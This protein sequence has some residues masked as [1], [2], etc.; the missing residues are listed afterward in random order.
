MLVTPTETLARDRTV[1]GRYRLVELLGEGGYGSVWLATD[2]ILRRPV[3]IKI[4]RQEMR[5][6][7]HADWV[8]RFAR[9]ARLIAAARHRAVV[10]V[11]DFG[12]DEGDP[13]LVMQVVDGVSMF[14]RFPTGAAPPAAAV[15]IAAELLAGLSVVHGAGIVHRD[16]KPENILLVDADESPWG[17]PVLIDFGISRAVAKTDGIRSVLTT[18]QGV[19]HGTPY[20]MAPEQA[21]GL[22]TDARTDVYS[23]GVLLF[24]MLAG[25]LPQEGD[26]P[27]TTLIAVGSQDAPALAERAPEVPEVLAQVVDRALRQD[28]ADR[29]ESAA[30]MRAALL[31][32]AARSGEYLSTAA[33][34]VSVRA[35]AQV[36]TMEDDGVATADPSERPT[37]TLTPPE[38]TAPSAAAPPRGSLAPEEK[39]RSRSREARFA[40]FPKFG[41]S[42]RGAKPLS[43]SRA[44]RMV[45]AAAGLLV[46]GALT[47][48]GTLAASGGTQPPAPS[49]EPA[50]ASVSAAR[51]DDAPAAERVARVGAPPPVAPSPEP[52]IE[53]GLDPPSRAAPRVAPARRV[54]RPR[55]HPPTPEP[56]A[57]GEASNARME[58]VREP[59]F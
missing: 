10:G 11:L 7:E 54:V 32:A 4:L 15:A 18:H 36:E 47:A 25:S 16:L 43:T 40:A 17:Q 30:A 23:V 51:A 56:P 3:A 59:G 38:P 24:E 35:T 41:G 21:R 2:P 20:Y 58:F 8:E 48:W 6:S 44:P 22:R 28:P 52:E 34:R 29:F 46:L 27:I 12:V 42:S 53:P 26:S 57:A 31:E 33:P 5:K 39:T 49:L 14:D 13:Y 55:P 45:V 50:P 19:V 37:T 9:E 1:G